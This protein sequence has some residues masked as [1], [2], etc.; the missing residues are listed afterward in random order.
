LFES[1]IADT[2]ENNSRRNNEEFILN[3]L[4]Q[5][6]VDDFQFQEEEDN[7]SHL[8]N[9]AA[10]EVGSTTGNP[11]QV[12]RKHEGMQQ[13]MGKKRP[14]TGHDTENSGEGNTAGDTGIV[15]GPIA[16]PIV[17][18]DG[19]SDIRIFRKVHRF[20]TFGLAYKPITIPRGSSGNTWNDVYM[21][22]PLA[23]IPWNR[24]FMYMNPSEYSLLPNG[25]Q[26]IHLH[27][28]IRQRNVRVAFQT[29]STTTEL[30]TLNQNKNAICADGLLQYC[31][32]ENVAPTA[33]ATNQAMIPTAITT[34]LPNSSYNQF[35][36]QFYGVQNSA[37]GFLTG[38]PRHQFGIPYILPFYYAVQNSDNDLSL[39]GWPCLQEYY[40]EFNA[41]ETSNT[42][43]LERSYTPKMGLIT[44]PNL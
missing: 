42:V 12:K 34:Q 32:G 10:A 28:K 24:L 30:A 41:D 39:S 7:M 17:N 26:V 36:D 13:G 18:R 25:S 5:A 19:D 31:G 35:I 21:T 1:D 23:E 8:P 44:T 37:P 11:G 29:N 6:Y 9:G 2:G 4:E 43:F 3:E 16:R 38:S 27:I 22:T 20:T 40:R 15:M 14:G 33:F